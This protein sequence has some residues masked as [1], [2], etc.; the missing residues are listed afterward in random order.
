MKIGP[1]MALRRRSDKRMSVQE[2]FAEVVHMPMQLPGA[3]V[4]LE[5]DSV[6][7]Q[8]QRPATGEIN[9]GELYHANSKLFPAIASGIRASR[10]DAV[11]M[12]RDFVTKRGSLARG[13]APDWQPSRLQR[14][15]AA[16]VASLGLP[17]FYAVQLR[18]A[19]AGAIGLYEP[20]SG[21]FEMTRRLDEADWN[22]IDAA[23]S[24]VNARVIAPAA[25]A[26]IFV[27]ASMARNEILYGR[28]G[29][30]RTLIEVGQVVQQFV[31]ASAAEQASC[32]VSLEF[33]DRGIDELLDL[34]G[35]EESVFAVLEIGGNNAG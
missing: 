35:V 32:S 21:T 29:Y 31:N 9:A 18:I 7:D 16:A 24:V 4:R 17:V 14:I 15:L 20:V 12:R 11:S 27:S 5:S 1:T 33:T 8:R 28:R 6:A 3:T 34:D 10:V 19:H 22:R 2:V 25:D 30:R 13:P 26:T 23:L